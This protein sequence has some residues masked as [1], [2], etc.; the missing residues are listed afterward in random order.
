MGFWYKKLHTKKLKKNIP[1]D[2]VP[3]DAEYLT[4]ESAA[5]AV[6]LLH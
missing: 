5:I 1:I 6:A 4:P 3:E 2:E